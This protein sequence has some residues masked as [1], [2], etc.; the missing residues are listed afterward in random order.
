[1][2]KF[3]DVHSG[4][5]GVATL[6]E[7]FARA[8]AGQDD[9]ALCS[10]LASPVDFQALTPGR[11]WQAA[12]AEQV[13]GEVILGP[14]FGGAEIRELCSVTT[15]QVAGRAHVGYRLRVWR[16]DREYLVEQQAYYD[17]DGG[18][19]TWMRVLCS[20]YQAV[21]PA[22]LSAR[23]SRRTGW[24]APGWRCRSWRRCARRDGWPSGAR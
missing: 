14:W 2:A 24:R 10:L 12:T 3:I 11:H 20:G 15:G 17:T 19:I 22:R 5:V 21:Q 13:V 9:A 7:R 4:F 1:M 23:G 8:L 16:S 18:Q 6:G